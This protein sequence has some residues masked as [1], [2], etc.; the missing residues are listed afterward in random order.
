MPRVTSVPYATANVTAPGNVNAYATGDSLG[1]DGTHLR[2]PGHHA[3]ARFVIRVAGGIRCR[4]AASL[5]SPTASTSKS[6]VER[7]TGGMTEEAGGPDSPPT[8]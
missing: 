5:E 6:L 3:P 8:R 1:E 7:V 2:P 4:S